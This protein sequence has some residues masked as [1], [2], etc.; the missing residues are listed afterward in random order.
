MPSS[1]THRRALSARIL[2][3]LGLLAVC[4]GAEPARA[5]LFHSQEEALV[6]AFPEADRITKKVHI[7]SDGEV[8][9]IESMARSRVETRLVAI[10]TAYRD[11][12]L[13]GYAHIDVHTVRTKPEGFMVVLRPDGSVSD[14]EILAFYEPLE[15]LPTSNWYDR[16]TGKARE[17]RL[18]VGRDVDAVT[19]ATL[20]ARAATEGVR[21]MLAYYQVLL[22][23]GGS[24]LES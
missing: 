12:E 23:A 20:S 21:R 11:G 5:K 18:R 7:L 3:A 22:G 24:E 9:A 2:L 1:A 6:L 15:Y 10:H 13:L 16:F 19:G 14:V 8:E 17:D 4:G